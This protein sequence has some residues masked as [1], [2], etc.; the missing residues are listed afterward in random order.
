[1]KEILALYDCRSKQEYIYRTNQVKEIS[2][3]SM[4]LADIFSSFFHNE[5]SIISDW[6]N[7]ASEGDF[8]ENFRKSGKDGEIIYEGGGNLCM[9]YKDFDTYILYNKKLSHKA[10][11]D[12]FGVSIIASCTEVTNDFIS[13]RRKLYKE[14]ALQK[15]LG[16]YHT[17]CN[18]MPFT[19]V[20]R[21]TF[22]AVVKKENDK[23]YTTE[24]LKKRN[25]YESSAVKDCIPDIMEVEFDKMVD[26]GEESLL[27]IIYIDGNNMGAKVKKVTEKVNNYTEGVNA[28]RRFSVQTNSDFVEKPLEQITK[29]LRKKYNEE[30]NEKKKKY[31]LFRPV[32]SGGDEIT[33]VCNAHAVPLILET[34]FKELTTN[35]KNSACAG[36]AVFHSHDPFA[37]VYEITEQSCEMGKKESHKAGNENNN[38]IDFHYCHSGITNDLETIRE[39][40]EG[41]YTARPYEFSTSWKKFCDLGRMLKSANRSDVKMLG[42]SVVKGDS[43]YKSALRMIKSRNKLENIDEKDET[44]KKMIYDISVVFDLWFG[45]EEISEND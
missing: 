37:D 12:T 29:V 2:G 19:Q 26:K 14:N 6:K 40:Q 34:Y 24:S 16:A 42:E 5:Q 43:Y 30:K 25:K 31:Y 45:G 32:I 10:L 11:T 18:V 28:L 4:L 33:I 39:K 27:A 15:N 23:M 8:L 22:Q 35:G 17:P 44:L 1:M 3:A 13:D 41:M 9:I 38:Y 7:V 36:V 21:V 20:D